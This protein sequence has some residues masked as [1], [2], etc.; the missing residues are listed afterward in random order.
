MLNRSKREFGVRQIW[1]LG[2]AVSEKG[3]EPNPAKTE[4]IKAT[5]SPNNV[6]DLLLFLGSCGYVSKFISNYA[7]I[8]ELLRK[9]TQKE[10]KGS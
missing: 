3:I 9:L 1:I 4:A 7:N 5:P 6:S 8:V 2:H 10:Q